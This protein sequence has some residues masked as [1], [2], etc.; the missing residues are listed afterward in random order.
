VL[1][2]AGLASDVEVNIDVLAADN[3]ADRAFEGTDTTL[4]GLAPTATTRR[5]RS[6][7]T[8]SST[9]R[10]GPDHGMS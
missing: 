7:W 1:D 6:R 9:S 8:T 5:S 10:Q 2:P 3:D 4:A